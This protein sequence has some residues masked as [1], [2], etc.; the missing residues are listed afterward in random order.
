[1]RI[2]GYLA[3]LGAAALLLW[4]PEA[5]LGADSSVIEKVSVKLDADFGE[6]EEIPEPVITASGSGYSLEDVQYRTDYDRWEPGKKVRVE[7]QLGAEDGKIF[8]TSLN[9][10]DCKVSGA[11]FVSAK[12]LDD[13]TLQVKVDYTPIMV[14]GNPS[15]AGWSSTSDKRAVWKKVEYA[16]G[17]TLTLYGDDKVVKRMNVESSSADLSDYMTEE[18]VT[19]YYEV[20]AVPL[21]SDERKYLKEGEYVT[22]EDTEVAYDGDQENPSYSAGDGGTVRG[23]NYVYPDGSLARSVWKKTGEQWRYYNGDGQMARG[24]AN[25]GG[26][27]YYMDQNGI[28]QTGW[29]NP[30]DGWFYLGPDGTM[31][32][33]WL[34]TGP[35]VWYYL[36]PYGYMESQWILVGG[37]WY[38]MEADGRMKTGW[39]DWKGSWYYLNPDGSMAVNQT[40]DGWYLGPDGIGRR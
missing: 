25:V 29:V 5:A 30:G 37:K 13:T 10:S 6:Q 18:G 4:R 16:P 21:T 40:V 17:Y 39:L 15:E 22:S 36:N 12:A 19:Y 34:S 28:M 23:D 38:F 32:T 1:M 11:D 3:A 33:G 8:P 7:I 20:K 9:R 27:W 2:K 31:R 24:W 35:G 26:Y 14:L